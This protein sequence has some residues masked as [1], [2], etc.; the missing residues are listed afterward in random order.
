MEYAEPNFLYQATL[1]PNDPYYNQQNYLEK[2]QAQNAW[3]ITTGTRKP[4][5]A[6]IDSGLAVDHP[7]L[8]NNI[9]VNEKEIPNNG[10]DDDENGFTDDVNGWDF[11][12]NN[13]DPQPKLNGAYSEIGIK[14][15]TVIAGVA[16]A[17]GGNGQGVAGLAWHARIMS[18]R[19]LDGEGAGDTLTVA[20]AI[21]YARLMKVDII[22]LSF[23]G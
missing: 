3:N 4:I 13:N 18:L 20:K 14:H 21:D 1:I 11:L 7:D 2:I 23:V 5:I 17:E 16:A 6:I 15:G 9:W 19:V 12:A 10:I 8:K 22:N